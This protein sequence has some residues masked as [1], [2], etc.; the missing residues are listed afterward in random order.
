[1]NTE[2]AAEK[3][4]E[5]KQAYPRGRWTVGINPFRSGRPAATPVV[6]GELSLEQVRPVRNDLTDTDLELQPRKEEANV[7]A[8]PNPA[9]VPAVK[10]SRWQR[11]KALFV[12]R[13]KRGGKRESLFRVPPSGLR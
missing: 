13:G 8:A 11:L 2:T 5:V 12:R 9:A 3:N 10:V 1:M 6:Q 4:A 7:F